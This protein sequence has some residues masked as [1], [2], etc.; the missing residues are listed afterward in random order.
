MVIKERFFAV[1]FNE[2]FS[3]ITTYIIQYTFLLRVFILFYFCKPVFVS[4]VRY[5][6]N[7]LLLKRILVISTQTVSVFIII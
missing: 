6:P 4:A 2:P 3:L 1:K 7:T 5:I